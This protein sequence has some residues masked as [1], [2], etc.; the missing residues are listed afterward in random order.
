M[1]EITKEP[2]ASIFGLAF[3]F[4]GAHF[5][6]LYFSP[7]TTYAN[8]FF[9]SIGITLLVFF[10]YMSKGH[11]SPNAEIF[12][13]LVFAINIGF[14]LFNI[15]TNKE[16][17]RALSSKISNFEDYSVVIRFSDSQLKVGIEKHNKMIDDQQ[18]LE[19]RAKEKQK[20][21]AKKIRNL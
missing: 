21:E 11:S 12:I 6:F 8:I 7:I 15:N 19:R 9:V 10:L 3:I 20:I 1:T 17:E 18:E 2:I 14:S 4:T 5:L 13:M 16:M